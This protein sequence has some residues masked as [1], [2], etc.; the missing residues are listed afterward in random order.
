MRKA[1][2]LGSPALNSLRLVPIPDPVV[3]QLVLLNRFDARRG[4]M[5]LLRFRKHRAFTAI[6]E[7]VFSYTG[8]K[9]IL[10][11]EPVVKAGGHRNGLDPMSWLLDDDE[12]LLKPLK[13]PKMLDLQALSAS[14]G[15]LEVGDFG[16]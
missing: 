2:Q 5:G 13:A 11:R 10:K 9:A 8:G 12:R 14:E 3:D 4:P 15:E 1:Q 16:K 6:A 7:G